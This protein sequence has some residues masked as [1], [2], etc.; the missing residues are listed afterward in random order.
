[1]FRYQREW[2]FSFVGY[3]VFFIGNVWNLLNF[4]SRMLK[5]ALL[6]SVSLLI[7]A[8]CFHYTFYC[9]IGCLTEPTTYEPTNQQIS[10]QDWHSLFPRKIWQVYL[11]PPNVESS[12][13]EID[14]D[15][16]S[17]SVSWLAHNPDY[18]YVLVGDEGAEAFVLQHFKNN[19][20]LLRIFKELKNTGMKSD[21]LRYMILSIEGGVYS[22]I[23]TVN[24]KPIDL[25]VPTEY[26]KDVRAVIGV[27]FDR[28]D[29]S[30]W[31]DVH[32]DLQFCQWTISVTPGHVLLSYMVEWV[33]SAL[34][35]FSKERQISYSEFN[36][37]S[38][39]V[40]HLTGPIAWTDVV[41]RRLQ[42]YDP[43]L[44]SLRNLSGLTEPRLVGDILLLPIDGFGM[45]Q[46]HSKSTN[47]GSVPEDALVQHKFRGSW[48]HGNR[49]R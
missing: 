32:P 6:T 10:S 20:T 9:H 41:F 5:I 3:F 18:E 28:L 49:S 22:D 4:K 21:L 40:M 27:E 48:R 30:N 31:G 29:G 35:N 43:G 38:T 45:G 1:M 13:F 39:D 17:D 26:R 42:Q 24:L 25:W 16:L 47:D 23:D 12:S 2:L 34:E 7:L 46:L 36:V 8:T 11:T 19:K 15:E 14:P 33:V 44:T 37:S